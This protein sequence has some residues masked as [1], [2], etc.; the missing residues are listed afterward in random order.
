MNFRL[1]RIGIWSAVKIS[2]LINGI[3]GAVFG[4]FA[5]LF[6]FMFGAL[7]S[8]FGDFAG[9]SETF[10]PLFGGAVAI[11]IMPFF[12]GFIMA[13]FNGIIFTAIAAWLYNVISGFVGGI[14]MHLE[15]IRVEQI[16]KPVTSP[17]PYQPEQKR[18]DPPL[19]SEGG[20]DV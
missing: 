17:S 9:G 2:F 11:I 14:E 20:V 19:T 16:S 3:I 6:I 4:F 1:K 13:V 18:D 8:Q 5:G 12:Y 7:L 10:P 15:D